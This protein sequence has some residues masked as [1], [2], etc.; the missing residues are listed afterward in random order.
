[1]VVESFDNGSVFISDP[2][3]DKQFKLNVH[4][5]KPYLTTEPP[6]LADKLNL[7]LLEV[8]EDMIMVT[9]SSHR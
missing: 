7:Y 3:S 2:K 9:P 1:M 4:R 5:L 6:T 8:H